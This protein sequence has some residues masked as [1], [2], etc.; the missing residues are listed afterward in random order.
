MRQSY[1]LQQVEQAAEIPLE[2]VFC[3]MDEWDTLMDIYYNGMPEGADTGLENLDR[4]IK[5]ER[6]FVLT[7]TGVPPAAEKA[8]LW[9]K[10]PCACSCATIGR[11]AISARR[12]PRW[13][14]TTAS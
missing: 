14:I 3:P 5:F 11:W 9:T 6:G 1:E 8:S 10:L 12:I 2:G 13:P 4:L 7:V